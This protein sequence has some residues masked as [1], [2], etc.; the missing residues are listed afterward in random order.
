EITSKFEPFSSR[1]KNIILKGLFWGDLK[2]S[3]EISDIFYNCTLCGACKEFCFNAHNDN[4]DFPNHKW[5]DQVEVYEALRADLVEAGFPLEAHIPMNRAMVD[6]LNP[7]GRNNEEKQNWT[8]KLDFKIPDA[9]E[10]NVEILYFVGCTAALTPQIEEI[11]IK[12]AKILKKLG[13]NFGIFGKR[14]ICCGS[15]AKRTGD[16]K[17]FNIVA[18]KNTNLFK[19]RGIKKI[20]TSCA[21]CYRTLKED[22]GKLLGDIEILHTVEFLDSY[23]DK[24]NI[25][26]KKLDKKVTYHD[27][28]H[29]GRHM[30]LYE[31]PRN[32]LK[33]ISTLVEMRTNREGAMCCG[34]GGGVKKGAPELS[35]AMAINRIKEAEETGVKT[36]VSTCPFCFRN[37]SDGIEAL[38]LDI[39]MVD[40]VELVLEV[41]DQ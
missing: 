2:L 29:L 25:K 7:Y 4:I 24:N 3:K 22:Y 9:N 38:G 5:M 1:G 20:I 35:T 36:L 15:V 27:P 14:E 34:A 11:A 10:E 6:F 37:L 18:E 8:D 32:I 19:E 28:C 39:K 30:N 13:I 26:L 40:L 16:L 41:L 33:K 21:G 12:T 23:I 17:A 31:A